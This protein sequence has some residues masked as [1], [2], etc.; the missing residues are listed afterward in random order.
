[1]VKGN[2]RAKDRNKTPPVKIRAKGVDL[3]R[4]VMLKILKSLLFILPFFTVC[5]MNLQSVLRVLYCQCF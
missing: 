4:E 5:F 2:K 3:D 1:M